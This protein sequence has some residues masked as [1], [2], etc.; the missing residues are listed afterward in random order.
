MDLLIFFHGL[1]HICDE[2][3]GNDADNVIKKFNFETQVDTDPQLALAVPIVMWN[4]ADRSRGFIKSAWSAAY[5][6]GY[7]EEVLDQ[8]G[9]SSVA[10]PNLGRLILSGHSAAYDILTP[11]ADQFDS[12]VA[13]TTKGALAKLDRVLAL[14]TTY[15]QL[16]AMALERWARKRPSVKFDLVLSKWDPSLGVWNSWE[17]IRKK[18]T[19]SA[20]AP[21]NL[22]VFRQT[23]GHCELPPNFMV[24]KL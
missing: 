1:L 24:K 22:R 8:I 5:I 6:N 9:Q 23:V 18:F 3:H 4:S 7:V 10:R 15:R 13:D 21:T 11:L 2:K 17:K 20:A 19:G 12:D 16:D 14:D